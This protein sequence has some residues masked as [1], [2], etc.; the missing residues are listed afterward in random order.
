MIKAVIFDI[1]NTLYSYDK[2]HEQAFPKLAGYA[3]AELGIPE[4]EFM[5]A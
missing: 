5:E 2:A 1:D 4:A 3:E